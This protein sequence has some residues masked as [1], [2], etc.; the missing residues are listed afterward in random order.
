VRK[1]LYPTIRRELLAHEKGEV[2]AVYPALAQIPE[3]RSV[4]MR[5]HDDAKELEAGVTAVDAL[6]FGD[7]NWG[8]AFE[9]IAAVVRSTSMK[10]RVFVRGRS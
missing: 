10:K 7:A 9:Q 6:A 2:E 8:A 5:H 3:T 1:D 4:A